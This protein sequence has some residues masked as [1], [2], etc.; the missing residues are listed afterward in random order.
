MATITET[1]DRYP[2]RVEYED[3]SGT[4]GGWFIF[5]SRDQTNPSTAAN[6]SHV[7]NNVAPWLDSYGNPTTSWFYKH[8]GHAEFKYTVT[9]LDPTTV[10]PF[11]AS[12]MVSTTP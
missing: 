9:A 11:S 2:Y 10:V 1:F 3:P 4:I 8:F 6:P 5:W 7:P 12:D